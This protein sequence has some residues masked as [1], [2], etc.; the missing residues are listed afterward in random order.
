MITQFKQF[1]S[2]FYIDEDDL[3]NLFSQEF[4]E[5]YCDENFTIEPEEA[6]RSLNIWNY[7]DKNQVR[8]YF[9]RDLSSSTNI[10][11]LNRNDIEECLLSNYLNDITPYLEKLRK[12]YNLG[13][14]GYKEILSKIDKKDFNELLE[15]LD[16]NEEIIRNYYEEKYEDVHPEEILYDTVGKHAIEDNLY[17]YLQ[18]FIDDNQIIED[19]IKNIDF[20]NKYEFFRDSIIHDKNLQEKII[21]MDPNTIEVLFDIIDTYDREDNFGNHYKFQKL[22]LDQYEGEDESIAVAMKK[23]N[24]KFILHPDIKKEYRNYMYLID[25]ESYN[26]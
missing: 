15:D 2:K 12:K 10:N 26:L 18:D 25:A 1:E 6:S 11:K 5:E 16:E 4:I 14:I 8:D 23:I 13:D 19:Y 17:P 24:D 3:A 22:Y 21:E 7:V 20:T 9:I